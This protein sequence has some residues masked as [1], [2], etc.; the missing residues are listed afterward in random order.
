MAGY[1]EELEC[2]I[3]KKILL[4]KAFDKLGDFY[5]WFDASCIKI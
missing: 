3:P 4:F 5:W 1:T 2:E